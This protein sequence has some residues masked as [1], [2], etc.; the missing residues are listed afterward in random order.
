MSKRVQIVGHVTSIADDYQGRQREITIDVTLNEL[1]VHDGNLKG[2]FKLARADL[3]NVGAATAS[4]AGKMTA[5]QVTELTNATSNIAANLAAI[6]LN[7]GDIAT[8][9]AAIS[10]NIAN[11]AANLILI[12]ANAAAITAGDLLALKIA[13]NLADLANVST[14]RNNLGLGSAAVLNAAAGTGDVLREASS[15]AS[16]TGI[17]AF[18]SGTRMIFQQNLAPT[19]WV[20]ETNSAFNNRALRVITGTVGAG[21][22]SVDM[23]TIF[24]SG[25]VTGSHA[26][27]VAEMPAHNHPGSTLINR[28]GVGA[29]AS[30]TGSLSNS[31]INDP[32][33]T[34]ASQ[35]GGSGHTHTLNLDLKY[36]DYIIAQKA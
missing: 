4:A 5:A 17:E 9:T 27:S 23:S 31:I 10:T 11:I 25:K 8:N 20:K 14:A 22:G 16:L 12:N 35:G 21:T 18:P 6:I 2:G 19:G 36:T 3:S 30:V 29:L 1:R 26:I 32:L 7:D 28:L 33:V 24:G 34:V 13:Q 15:G